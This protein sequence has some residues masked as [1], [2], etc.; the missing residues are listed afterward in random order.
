[1][2]EAVL[3]QKKVFAL[4]TVLELQI[5]TT[6]TEK[7]VKNGDRIAQLVIM[8]FLDVDFEETDDLD[9]TERGSGG[10]GSTGK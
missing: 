4:Q 10:F 1:M 5:R 7:T 8:P 3:R 9:E 6:D 2:Q